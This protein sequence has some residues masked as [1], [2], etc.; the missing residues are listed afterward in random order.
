MLKKTQKKSDRPFRL[1]LKARLRLLK[2]SIFG[3]AS[4]E[5]GKKT[6][7]PETS[8]EI[9]LRQRAET[10]TVRS[11]PFIRKK[12]RRQAVHRE[13]KGREQSRENEIRTG[14]GE[15]KTRQG[16]SAADAGTCRTAAGRRQ[17]K[18]LRS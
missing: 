8:S 17:N 4:T 2:K 7:L 12:S 5:E 3:T 13:T 15:K 1:S 18:I 16:F 14:A 6:D 11:A 9:S 10:G